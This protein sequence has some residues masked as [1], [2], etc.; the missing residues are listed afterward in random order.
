[1]KCL[2]RVFSLT[3]L[4]LV[5]GCATISK[6]TFYGTANGYNHAMQQFTDEQLLLNI[7]R[8]RYTDTPYFLEANSFTSQFALT[9]SAGVGAVLPLQGSN[10]VLNGNIGGSFTEQPTIS[11]T[12]L[13]GDDFFQQLLQQVPLETL[14]LLTNS[15]WS[16]DTVAR[17][18]IQR[19]NGLSNAAGASGPTPGEAPKFKE[20][21]A[22]ASLL[23]DLQRDEVILLGKD[24]KTEKAAIFLPPFGESEAADELRDMLG[25][26]PAI[27]IYA[28]EP[29]G[30]ILMED[31]SDSIVFNTRSVLGI[32]F[33]L[34]QGV[35]TP[36]EHEE[37]GLVVITENPD[38]TVFDWNEL[39]GD[40]FVVKSSKSRPK[41]A[42]MAVQHRGYWFYIENSDIDTKTTFV[43]LS[44]MFSLQTGDAKGQ[45]PILTLP[46]AL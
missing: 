5:S 39:L 11:Y 30:G 31:E 41:N 8:L 10:E 3:L 1:M 4:L 33:F 14:G 44:Q 36:A 28:V 18:A 23:F 17:M 43:L 20:F 21:N 6:S 34:S 37:E 29:G 26:D 9:T 40:L 16:F 46:V 38:G 24:P 19:T 2:V 35:D 7:V 27:T 25:L 15:G 45:A 42:S 32:L 22:V 12:P 13:Q